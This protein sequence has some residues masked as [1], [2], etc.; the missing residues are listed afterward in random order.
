VTA[1]NYYIILGV[2]EHATVAEI[3]KAYRQRAR[4]FHPDVNTNPDAKDKF[5][6]LTEAYEYLLARHNNQVFEEKQKDF[7]KYKHVTVD[8]NELRR[9]RAKA[10]A[11]E[12]ARQRYKDFLKSPVYKT[13]RTLNKIA[14]LVILALAFLFPVMA[15]YGLFH[16]GLYILIDNEEVLNYKALVGDILISSLGLFV[17]LLYLFK[18]LK[19]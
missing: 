14:D 12:Y 8:W 19:R 10:R 11:R 3:K 2:S 15:N 5:I 6:L 16:T 9:E 1:A 4:Q 18:L 13:T 17:L 7:V